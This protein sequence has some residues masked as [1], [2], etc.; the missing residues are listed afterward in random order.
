MNLP[1]EIKSPFARIAEIYCPNVYND[2]IDP[3]SSYQ[4]STFSFTNA[5]IF[6][7]CM[8]ITFL[9]IFIYLL[10]SNF[11]SYFRCLRMLTFRLPHRFHKSTH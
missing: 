6:L 4:S 8:A 1:I 9:F 2:L 5:N 11:L 10:V 3:N 7:L